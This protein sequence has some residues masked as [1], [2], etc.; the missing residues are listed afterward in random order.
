MHWAVACKEAMVR[1]V[2]SFG[3]SVAGADVYITM[4][5]SAIIRKLFTYPLSSQHFS[6]CTDAKRIKHHVG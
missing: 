4:Y 1:N 5:V 6:R 2:R 3:A